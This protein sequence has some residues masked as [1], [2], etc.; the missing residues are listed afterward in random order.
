MIRRPPRST[1]TDPLFPYTTLFRSGPDDGAAPR[2]ES[3]AAPRAAARISPLGGAQ[4]IVVPPVGARVVRRPD[5]RKS[6]RSGLREARKFPAVR[7]YGRCGR[8]AGAKEILR[9][10]PITG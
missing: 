3:P 1:R 9:G 5:P 7:S 10:V 2:Y 6:F 4:G 8:L